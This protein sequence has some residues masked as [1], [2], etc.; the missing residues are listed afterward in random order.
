MAC[1]LLFA[2]FVSAVGLIGIVGV[3]SATQSGDAIATDELTT[4]TMTAQLDRS[5]DL[6]YSTAEQAVLTQDASQRVVLTRSLYSQLIPQVDVLLTKLQAFHAGDQS[7]EL[8]DFQ[9]FADQWR[10]L[11][12]LLSSTEAIGASHLV[13]SARLTLAYQ[14]LSRHIDRLILNEQ[15][16]ADTAADQASAKSATKLWWIA[17]AMALALSTC[18]CLGC[19]GRRLI[20]KAVEPEQDQSDFAETLQM[21][22]DE[23]EA[24]QL[25]QGHLERSLIGCTAVVLNRNN[26]ADRLEAVTPLPS[27]SPLAESLSGAQP[28]SCLAVRSGR[29]HSEST[30]HPGLLTCSV[31]SN[32]PGD[33]SCVPLTVGGEVIGSVLLIR[34][35]P[36]SESEEHRIRES[37][38]QAAPILANLRNLAVAEVRAATD[39]LTGLPNKRAVTDTMKQLFAQAAQ[40]GS[41]LTLIL[42]D[43]DHFKL[44]NDQHGHPVGDQVLATV[45][46]VLR[47][48]LRA[49]DF[50]ARN[51]GEEFA[52]VLPDTD[53]STGMYIAERVRAAIANITL[54][55]VDI[56]VTASLGVAGYP[57]HASSLERLER[58]ADAALYVAKRSG[59]NRTE[60]ADP[61]N[62]SQV[63]DEVVLTNGGRDAGAL[64]T[65]AG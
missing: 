38:N 62:E 55:D 4:S 25:L 39:G 29:S 36:F 24:H 14:P 3:R 44:I 52:L 32:C 20:R 37:V 28:R 9:L 33:S 12:N 59:R 60:L 47:G 8:H 61:A 23:E 50:G 63:F 13:T 57:D 54:P 22:G 17:G 46:A 10:A 64:R 19:A 65:R 21:A 42:L 16:Y 56:S 43:L 27:G 49:G 6:V 26:S 34:D 51:G 40:T 41:P 18:V 30:T 31:C 48:A 35:T 7:K 58:L 1:C 5:M 53:V 15:D 45:G 11:R 2:L